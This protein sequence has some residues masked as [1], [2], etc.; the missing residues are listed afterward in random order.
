M[1]LAAV[2]SILKVLLK[3]KLDSSKF[4]VFDH[5]LTLAQLN[6]IPRYYHLRL[7]SLFLW[8]DHVKS[9]QSANQ[10]SSPRNFAWWTSIKQRTIRLKKASKLTQANT[11]NKYDLRRKKCCNFI[12]TSFNIQKNVCIHKKSTWHL[13]KNSFL[14]Y[15]YF[16]QKNNIFNKNS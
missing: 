12:R 5:L 16:M 14:I 11:V 7:N 8:T 10:S 15:V 6:Q 4:D 9:H 1:V 13:F 2:G 3:K